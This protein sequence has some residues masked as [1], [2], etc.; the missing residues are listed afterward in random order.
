MCFFLLL[1][2]ISENIY[3]VFMSFLFSGE[4]KSGRSVEAPSPFTWARNL[5]Y[6]L[7]HHILDN[8]HN[9]QSVRKRRKCSAISKRK[10]QKKSKVKVIKHGA[11]T[12]CL[13]VVVLIEGTLM[14]TENSK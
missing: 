8:N 2:R 11:I 6:W 5:I 7:C 1:I 10:S 4:S 3:D 13:V 14:I 9:N 12:Q